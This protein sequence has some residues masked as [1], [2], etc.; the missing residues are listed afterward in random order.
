MSVQKSPLDVVLLQ[1]IIRYNN[2]LRMTRNS[3]ND[4]CQA[5][6]GLVVMSSE[7][8]DIFT[9]ILEGRVPNIWSRTYPSLMTLGT[10]T[11]DLVLRVEHITNWAQTVH[12]PILFW[13]S[14][15]TFPTG[16]LTAV[17]QTASRD[18]AVSIDSLSWE[19][20]VFKE[21][22]ESN[23]EQPEVIFRLVNQYL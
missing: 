9:C 10:W 16:F 8:D 1:E 13:L 17:L 22:I 14:A 2:L 23:L 19:F 4:L 15:F 11:R 20:N 18:F 12:P 7:L 21:G 6:Q 3:L 5:I